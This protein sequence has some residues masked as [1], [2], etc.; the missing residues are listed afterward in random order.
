MANFQEIIKS[1]FDIKDIGIANWILKIRLVR[2]NQN[3]IWIGQS[4]RIHDMLDELDMWDVDLHNLPETPMASNWKH[5]I[6]DQNFLNH[7]QIT[8]Y[9]SLL[10]KLSYIAQQTRPDII[11]AVN[12][13]AQYQLK[14]TE[15]HFK[16][17]L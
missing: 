12:V 9:K 11:Y 13:L 10:M 17:L 3:S 5:N 15:F 6:N 2:I 16:S 4:Q 14:P 8:Q 7:S 1:K